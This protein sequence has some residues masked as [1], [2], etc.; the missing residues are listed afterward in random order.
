MDETDK[1]TA[2]PIQMILTISNHDFNNREYVKAKVVDKANP[3]ILDLKEVTVEENG[4]EVKR[5]VYKD[6]LYVKGTR[7]FKHI[8]AVVESVKLTHDGTEYELYL[9]RLGINAYT[10]N[11][12]KYPKK[13]LF[14]DILNPGDKITI[15]VLMNPDLEQIYDIM[16]VHSW[17]SDYIS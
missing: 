12:R 6:N 5:G 7:I 15:T 16:F 8:E 2:G 13:F 1:T 4:C 17:Y 3:S 14:E 9:P 10:G 11:V